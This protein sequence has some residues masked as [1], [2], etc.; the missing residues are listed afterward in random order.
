MSDQAVTPIAGDHA[1]LARR[2]GGALF[3]LAEHDGEVDAVATDLRGL[4]RVWDE[5]AE[6][7]FIAGDPRLTSAEL[8]A[9]AAETAKICGLGKLATSFL[10]L[11]AQNRRLNV[12]PAMIT[13]F[14]DEMAVKRGEH[15]AEVHTARALTTA[16]RDALVAAL[17]AAAGGKVH[18][19][20]TEDSSLLGGLTVKMGSQFIDASVKNRLDH[21]ERTLKGAA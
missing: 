21:L 7:R 8:I 14:L 12:L 18:L 4:R 3:A 16:Q 1:A 11:V 17:N 13:C 6:W 2:Y 10:S 9:A 20:V 15:N 5:S 19:T